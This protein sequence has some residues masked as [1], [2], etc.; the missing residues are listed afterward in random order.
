MEAEKKERL[1]TRC[2]VMAILRN[3]PAEQAVALAER[4][5]DLGIDMVE[6][7]IQKPEFVEALQAV[8]A[9]GRE[10][11]KPVGAGTVIDGEQLEV[12]TALG[13]DFAVAPGLD[14]DLARRAEQR[15][16][17]FI[18]GV[19]TPSEVQRALQAGLRWVKAFPATS[20]GSA[21]FTAIRGPFP[22]IALVATGGLDASNA[23][24]YLNAGARMVAVGSALEDPRQLELLSELL[25]RGTGG[26]T[27]SGTGRG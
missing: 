18:P 9:A 6:V 23:Q 19:A 13:V 3:M 4:A 12:V 11:G 7:P 2:P 26:G 15:G 8:V 17:P 27:G 21:W 24:Q 14:V 16:I 1:M 5:W 10:R 22:D 20:L 25:D